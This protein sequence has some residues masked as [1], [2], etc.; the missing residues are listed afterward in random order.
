MGAGGILVNY[1]TTDKGMGKDNASTEEPSVAEKANLTQPNK[2]TSVQPTEVKTK[3]DL[4]NQKVVTQ[5]NEDAPEVTANSKKSSQPVATEPAKP[6]KKQVVNANALYKGPSK[7][8][9]GAGDGTTTTPGNQGSRN[10][11][12]L[13]SNYG[14]GGT[15][16]GLKGTQ[17]SYVNRPIFRNPNNTPGFV[18]IDVT[19]DANGNIIEAHADRKTRMS[20]LELINRCIEII[21]NSK[22]TSPTPGSGIQK[23]MIPITFEVN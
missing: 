5:N 21:K 6:V 12:P 14:D 18:Y 19:I 13:T 22:L 4:S 2:V 23:S 7:A 11:S 1:G 8:G 20:D 10:G 9:P 15:G 17:W 3:T 16:N